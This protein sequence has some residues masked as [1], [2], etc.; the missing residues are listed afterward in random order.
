M[1]QESNKTAPCLCRIG[2]ED[3]EHFLL[4]CPQFCWE[5]IDLF[6]QLAEV[7][8]LDMTDMYSKAL[9]DLL[10]YGSD[11]LNI[12]TIRIMIEATILLIEK[13]RRFG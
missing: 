7:P 8:D 9:C 3:N 6:H 5:R 1:Y 4:H 10:S 13:T 2:D 12:L 11:D